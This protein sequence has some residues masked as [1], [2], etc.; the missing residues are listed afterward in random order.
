MLIAIIIISFLLLLILFIEKPIIKGGAAIDLQMEEE[1][2]KF[3]ITK[4]QLEIMCDKIKDPK[5]IYEIKKKLS[6]ELLS[7]NDLHPRNMMID[8]SNNIVVLDYGESSYSI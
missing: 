4:K 6:C 7:H 3:L 1:Y 2:K 5:K 8:S